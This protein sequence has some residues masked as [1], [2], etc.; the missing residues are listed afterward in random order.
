MRR[1]GIDNRD[2]RLELVKKRLTKTRPRVQSLAV[3]EESEKYPDIL[4]FP[5]PAR[6]PSLEVVVVKGF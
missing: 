3:G 6:R 1:F 5:N 4:S 2:G